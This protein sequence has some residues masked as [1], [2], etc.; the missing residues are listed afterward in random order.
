M[1]IGNATRNDCQKP[2]IFEI[3][4]TERSHS[5]YWNFVPW[6]NFKGAIEFKSAFFGCILQMKRL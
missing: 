6:K 1:V 2:L 5:R 3:L 4:D